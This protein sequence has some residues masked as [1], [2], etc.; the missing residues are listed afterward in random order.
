[1][2]TMFQLDA[3]NR[4]CSGAVSVKVNDVVDHR[5]RSSQRPRE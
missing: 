1:M 2:H 3:I 5:R 4:S